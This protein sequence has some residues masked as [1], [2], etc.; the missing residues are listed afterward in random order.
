[1]RKHELAVRAA[2]GA[3]R[4]RLVRQMLT[5]SVVLALAG[6]AAGV[7]VAALALPLLAHLV[8]TTLPLADPPRLDLRALA[9]A[10]AFTM[11]VGIGFGLIPAVAA[12]G[13]TGLGALREGARGGGGR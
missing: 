10:G 2:L 13:Q 1:A 7:L 5:E 9:I 3:G 8:P 12:G 6:G 11:L 4:E